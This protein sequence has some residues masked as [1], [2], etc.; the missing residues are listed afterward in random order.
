M[1]DG[2]TLPLEENL[3][4]SS[5]LLDECTRAGVVLEVECGVVGGA[6]DDVSGEAAERGRY[7]LAA[8]FGNVHGCYAPGEVQLRPEIL[9]EGQDALAAAHPGARFPYV[10]HGSSGSSCSMLSDKLDPGSRNHEGR[11]ARGGRPTL[12]A[13][14]GLVR[15]LTGAGSAGLAP[16]S[17]GRCR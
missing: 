13:L 16:A 7:L 10:F 2:S 4:V 9:R 6:E 1:F 12:A 15:G 3:R 14:L 8:T 11:G 17:L 5:E